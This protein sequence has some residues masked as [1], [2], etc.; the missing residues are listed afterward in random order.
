[1]HT[2]WGVQRSFL[3]HVNVYRFLKYTCALHSKFKLV[4]CCVI[5]IHYLLFLMLDI[6]EYHMSHKMVKSQCNILSENQYQFLNSQNK[7]NKCTNS[8]IIFCI[9][10]LS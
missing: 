9:C 10:N 4:L 1:M 7:T 5:L 2:K 8:K 6:V 3:Q